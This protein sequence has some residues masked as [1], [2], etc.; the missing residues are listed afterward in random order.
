MPSSTI[1][2][3]ELR[4]RPGAARKA[5]KS[6]VVF[7]TERGHLA[8][9]L[10]SVAEYERLTPTAGFATDTPKPDAPYSVQRLKTSEPLVP[11]KPKEFERA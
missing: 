11:P 7:I 5:A 2:S 3:T 9:A 4:R 8:Y 6:G 10:L 1:S